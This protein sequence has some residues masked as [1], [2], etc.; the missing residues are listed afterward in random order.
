MNVRNPLAGTKLI[1]SGINTTSSF[2]RKLDWLVAE[3]KNAPGLLS[4]YTA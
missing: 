4:Q 1:V 2:G 3:I